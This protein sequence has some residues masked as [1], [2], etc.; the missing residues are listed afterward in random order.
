MMKEVGIKDNLDQYESDYVSA[1][2]VEFINSQELKSYDINSLKYLNYYLFQDLPKISKQFNFSINKKYTPGEFRPS[3][4]D[5]YCW[6]KKRHLETISA[7]SLISYSLMNQDALKL[8][9]NTL[10]RINPESWKCLSTESFAEELAD[11][12]STLDFVHP[13]PDGNSR[14]LRLFTYL[15]AQDAQFNLNWGYFNK[16]A[17]NRDL[18][19]IARDKAVNNY[20]L[21]NFPRNTEFAID[22]YDSLMQ[23]KSYPGLKTLLQDIRIIRPL[24]AIEFEEDPVKALAGRDF[25][26]VKAWCL[27]QASEPLLDTLKAKAFIKE[28]L[29]EIQNKLDQNYSFAE[30]EQNLPL[31]ETAKRGRGRKI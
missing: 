30:Q 22:V 7:V 16:S 12:Y 29:N 25:N 13:F 5:D 8:L 20:Y 3:L 24:R 15:A 14:T 27:A 4:P 28:R 6:F 26:D 21:K 18:L 23:F 11:I 1:R 10:S 9:E 31:H 2:A 17:H 19:Y